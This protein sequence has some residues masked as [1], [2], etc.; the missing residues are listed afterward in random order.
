LLR[1][2]IWDWPADISGR[3]LPKDIQVSCQIVADK[4][5]REIRVLMGAPDETAR[6]IAS[7][8][9]CTLNI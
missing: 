4:N 7:I 9:H 5:R 2:S 8:L 3:R 1:K 6:R